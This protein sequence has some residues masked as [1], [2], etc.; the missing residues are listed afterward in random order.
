MDALRVVAVGV[1]KRGFSTFNL[2]NSSHQ[3]ALDDVLAGLDRMT[4]DRTLHGA[5]LP[6]STNALCVSGM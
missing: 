4:A 3:E 5:T 6:L 2:A 1:L